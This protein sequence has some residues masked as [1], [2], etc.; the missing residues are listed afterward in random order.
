MGSVHAHWP[1]SYIKN[2][3]KLTFV[4]KFSLKLWLVHIDEV[5]GLFPH[6]QQFYGLNWLISRLKPNHLIFFKRIDTFHHRSRLPNVT[7]LLASLMFTWL[8]SECSQMLQSNLII[9]TTQRQHQWWSLLACWR[10]VFAIWCSVYIPAVAFLFEFLE[11]L[12]PNNVRIRKKNF[13]Q[14]SAIYFT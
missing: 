13:I 4:L 3:K 14:T 9:L 1:S 6:M 11:F 10:G 8:F 2:K 7:C 5:K 12:E